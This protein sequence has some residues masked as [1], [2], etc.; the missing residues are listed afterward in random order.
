MLSKLPMLALIALVVAGCSSTTS[1]DA[2]VFDQARDL[3]QDLNQ[4]VAATQDAVTGYAEPQFAGRAIDRASS[5]SRQLAQTAASIQSTEL[6][7]ATTE[8]V[9]V[10]NRIVTQLT[11]GDVQ[12]AETLRANGFVPLAS[13]I[14]QMKGTVP[15]TTQS[16]SSSSGSSIAIAFMIVVL[17]IGGVAVLLRRARSRPAAVDSKSGDERPTI[18]SPVKRQGGER[19]W[20]EPHPLYSAEAVVESPSAENTDTA[21]TTRMRAI[22]IDLHSLLEAT[23]QQAKEREWMVSLVCPQV[24]VSGDPVRFQRAILAALGNAF[25]EGAELVGI[26]VDVID[27]QVLLSIGHDAPID[28]SKAEEIAVRLANQLALAVDRPELG[29][30]VAADGEIYLTTVSAGVVRV[31][32]SSPVDDHRLVSVSADTNVGA[33]DVSEPAV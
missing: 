29:W 2:A 18:A 27:D 22:D 4:A 13:E 19:T 30:S 14:A 11:Q 12:G 6:R 28:D 7:A 23:I 9:S 17:V 5:A 25:L 1:A 10:A 24:H 16:P 32:A 20:S 8:L 26:V 31:V 15:A 21:R 33:D 3:G